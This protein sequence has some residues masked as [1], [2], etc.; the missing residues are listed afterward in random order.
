M[1]KVCVVH[2]VGYP[3]QRELYVSS[4]ADFAR[5]FSD[6]TG[7]ETILFPWQH[8]GQPPVDKRDSWL[9]KYLRNWTD[10]IIMDFAHVLYHLDSIAASLPEA[11]MYIG[12]SA[13]GVIISARTDKPQV[14]M[15]CP[16]QLLYNIKTCVDRRNTLNIM[17]YRDPI[18][19]PVD[20][21]ENVITHEPRWISIVNPLEAHTSY[22]T[23]KEA[24]AHCVRWFNI[25]K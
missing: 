17:H 22:W 12:H 9:F 16:V 14:L 8:P 4:I 2:G 1:S 6:Q 19:A 23:S 3:D 18:A 13:G 15:A 11:D 7:A 10:E 25:H 21:A 5:A 24:L 20:G